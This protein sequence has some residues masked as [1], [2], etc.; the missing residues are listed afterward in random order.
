M[1]ARAAQGAL[2]CLG[3]NPGEPDGLAGQNIRRDAGQPAGDSLTEAT[4]VALMARAG[5]T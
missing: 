2:V 1:R 5:L 4:F 3:G